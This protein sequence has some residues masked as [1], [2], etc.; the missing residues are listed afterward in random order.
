[1]IRSRNC[2]LGLWIACAL[3]AS[4]R[5]S[6]SQTWTSNS[7]FGNWTSM[8]M[9][10]DG[11]KIAAASF[12]S[13]MYYSAN[14]GTSWSSNT[15]P[16]PQHWASLTASANGNNL[17]GA[18]FNGGIF[19]SA[20]WGQS[21][22][23]STAPTNT[24]NCI[25]SSADGTR[26][27]AG[28]NP[29]VLYSSHDGGATFTSRLPEDNGYQQVAASADG[30]QVVAAAFNGPIF[31]SFD[32]GQNWTTTVAPVAGWSAIASSTD[33]ARLVAAVRGGGIYLSTDSGQTWNLTA[34]PKT[35]WTTI[36][37]SA[38]G[39]R[40]VA[41]VD[42]GSVYT[43]LDSGATWVPAIIPAPIKTRGIFTDTVVTTITSTNAATGD[44][45]TKTSSNVFGYTNASIPN[46][47]A[48]AV[49]L[50]VKISGGKVTGTKTNMVNS[51]LG[52]T[53]AGVS[54]FSF[55]SISTNVFGTNDLGINTSIAKISRTNKFNESI[56]F[57]TTP[58]TFLTNY[59]EV[60]STN[61]PNLSVTVSN[62]LGVNLSIAGVPQHWS[63]LASSADGTRLVI[64]QLGGSLYHSQ[65][66]GASWAAANGPSTNW[67]AIASSADGVRLMAAVSG[68]WIY[69]SADGGASWSPSF[70]ITNFPG[71]TNGL[72]GQAW[73]SLACSDDGIKWVAAVNNGPIF[74]S[75]NF[76]TTWTTSSVPANFWSSVSSSS[77]GNTLVAVGKFGA[78]YQST[79]AG[80]TW[81]KVSAAADL[82][83]SLAASADFSRLFAASS[84][85]YRSTDSGASW[86]QLN[87]VLQTNL[88]VT[89]IV[90]GAVITTNST[91]HQRSTNSFLVTL[92]SNIVA[93]VTSPSFTATVQ[94]S[95]PGS[96]ITGTNTTS[97]STQAGVTLNG[98]DVF[99]VAPANVTA[100]ATNQVGDGTVVPAASTTKVVLNAPSILFPPGIP[101]TNAV[102]VTNTSSVGGGTLNAGAVIVSFTNVLSVTVAI[103]NV[104]RAWTELVSSADG[105]R[106]AAT[107]TN[108]GSI[109]L[110]GNSGD[111][112]ARAAVPSANWVAL[113]LSGDGQV[114]SAL[115]RNGQLYRSPD[116]GI[117]WAITNVPTPLVT[118]QF[119]CLASSTDGH[120]IAAALYQGSIYM[121]PVTGNLT[122]VSLPA[123]SISL[124]GTNCT[125]SWPATATGFTL[126]EN[127]NP[128]MS[129]TDLN[130]SPTAVDGRNEITVPITD[131]AHFYRLKK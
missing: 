122:S 35:I 49:T 8:A 31:R 63:S 91:T 87:T 79:D 54:A 129:W 80:Q 44:V 77:D 78:A 93:A 67:S 61:L 124:T 118:N 81:T 103:K 83:K 69:D 50:G 92:V 126:Q 66:S 59:S 57:P 33:G 15:A 29:G 110:S 113:S 64:A 74:V 25:V 38:D 99:P 105:N 34:A 20:N 30:Q 41:A 88:L 86:Q 48:V 89:N 102:T 128:T 108:T 60:L 45:H 26:L 6:F 11:Q 101:V 106:L 119:G 76:G 72:P 55:Q 68:G 52:L 7:V 58:G 115:S 85:L 19:T 2:W 117:T 84:F 73:S 112:W 5:L 51:Q 53:I 75:T 46:P 125:L 40:F 104:P 23:Q 98:T 116:F 13:G 95:T 127:Q 4:G 47:T 17:V 43:S 94:V 130:I 70:G 12:N 131:T 109:Y 90:S 14:A 9:T 107:E 36:A 1:M 96:T 21:W 114:L 65:N 56:F 123:L 111:S 32:A 121:D 62:S 42:A 22:T 16:D 100:I 3:L 24:W 82:W 10:A 39:T 37:A 71:L 27:L 120:V 18:Y 97:F 28:A